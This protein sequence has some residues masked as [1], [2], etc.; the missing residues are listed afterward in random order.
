MY[1]RQSVWGAILFIKLNNFIDILWKKISIELKN[2]YKLIIDSISRFAR[3]TKDLL[4]LVDKLN[5][6]GIIFISLK[7][8]IDTTSPTGV[9]MV[10]VFAAVAQLEHDYLKDRQYTIVF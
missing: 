1:I 8:A 6:K 4:E 5:S 10:T 9:F 2:D 7:E 3:N